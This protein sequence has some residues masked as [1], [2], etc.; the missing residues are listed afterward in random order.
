MAFL[1]PPSRA[2]AQT[3]VLLMPGPWHPGPRLGVL[4]PLGHS[5]VDGLLEFPHSG[6]N[7]AD[8]VE[9]SGLGV[10]K[11]TEGEKDDRLFASHRALK[12]VWKRKGRRRQ[13]PPG[14]RVQGRDTPRPAGLDARGHS[15][16]G[17][18]NEHYRDLPGG[19]PANS[20]AKLPLRSSNS[21]SGTFLRKIVWQEH[22]LRHRLY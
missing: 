11:V 14:L 16:P 10:R 13:G 20:L 18:E 8:V 9:G 17:A 1:R 12:A 15:R 3:Q 2:R 4:A 22:S 6:K 7:P 19:P 5:R 21:T